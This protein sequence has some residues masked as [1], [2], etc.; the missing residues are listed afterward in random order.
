M[1]LKSLSN[2]ERFLKIIFGL[3]LFIVL[4]MGGLAYRYIK[5]L[6]DSFDEVQEAYQLHIELEKLLSALK[7][8]ESGKRGF[9]ISKDSTFLQPLLISRSEIKNSLNQL[10]FLIHDDPEQ[11]DNVAQ[12]ELK[13]NNSLEIFEK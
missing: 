10:K 6:S 3:S 12:L 13:I 11:Q 4:V 9:I 7:D 8:A 1:K 5:N 2:S